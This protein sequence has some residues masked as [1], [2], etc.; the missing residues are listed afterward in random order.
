MEQV[1]RWVLREAIEQAARWQRAGLRLCVSINVSATDLDRKDFVD[2][3]C[4]VLDRPD[5]DP[6][7][8]ELEFTESALTRDPEQLNAH[9]QAV[10]ALGLQLSIDD[11]GTGYSNL[12]YLKRIPARTLKIDQS[13]IR[14]VMVDERDQTIVPS[15]IRLAHA[16]GFL[17]VA[18]GIETREILDLVSAWGCDEGQ[19]YFIARPMPAAALVRWLAENAQDAGSCAPP[20]AT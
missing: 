12:S 1:T 8:L 10:R 15:V 3:L 7:R 6:T 5:L 20:R 19:G 18:E 9:L 4:K 13:F 14:S 16:L 17:V 11:F 2:E